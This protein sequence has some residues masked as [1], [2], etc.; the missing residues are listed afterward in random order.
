[1]QTIDQINAG[2]RAFDS[3]AGLT[4][5]ELRT[6][7]AR[8][9]E[10]REKENIAQQVF[11]IFSDMPPYAKEVRHDQVVGRTY[12]D[13]DDGQNRDADSELSNDLQY[14]EQEIER[15][16]HPVISRTLAAELLWQDVEAARDNNRDIRE[17]KTNLI[18]TGHTRFLERI[19]WLGSSTYSGI[20]GAAETSNAQTV[21]PANNNDWPTKISSGNQDLLV[22]DITDTV[23]QLGNKEGFEPPFPVVLPKDRWALASNTYVALDQGSELSVLDVA[24]NNSMV[25]EIFF[26]QDLE[27]TSAGNSHT[28]VAV[29]DQEQYLDLVLP[30]PVN[31]LDPRRKM[32]ENV[33]LRARQVTGGLRIKDDQA[34]VQMDG[35]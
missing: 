25:G 28:M 13:T 29:A 26:S 24:M 10:P 16:V 1:M 8:I 33:V 35:I 31:M 3:T 15:R 27:N 19:T 4:Q 23:E 34:I 21:N 22:Q 14:V 5:E 6:L 12:R 17:T 2:G 9:I 11:P 18:R 7:E 32:N 20:E 30:E